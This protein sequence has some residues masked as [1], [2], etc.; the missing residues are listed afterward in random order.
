M[1]LIEKKRY[2]YPDVTNMIPR[3]SFFAEVNRKFVPSL[4]SSFSTVEGFLELSGC[5][6]FG[7]D[8]PVE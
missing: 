3:P 7:I 8:S 1:K 5:R 6:Q 4:R 2:L